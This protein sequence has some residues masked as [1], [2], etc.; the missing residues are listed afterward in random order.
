MIAL[1]VV[2]CL[3]VSDLQLFRSASSVVLKSNNALAGKEDTNNTFKYYQNK[4]YAFDCRGIPYRLLMS[5]KAAMAAS[6]LSFS[7]FG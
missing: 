1:N 2:T 3:P 5:F 4:I 6:A 7:T